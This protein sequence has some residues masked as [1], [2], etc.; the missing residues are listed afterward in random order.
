ML[1]VCFDRAPGIF[2]PCLR[3][4]SIVLDVSFGRSS[5]YV[6][7]VAQSLFRPCSSYVCG[8]ARDMLRPSINM[9]RPFSRYVLTDLRDVLTIH[10]VYFDRRRKYVSTVVESCFDYA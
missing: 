1:D 4:V 2:Q 6:S 10:E 5:W 9:F 7:T 8:N 3:C